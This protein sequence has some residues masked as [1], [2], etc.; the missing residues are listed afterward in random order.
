MMKWK[1]MLKSGARIAGLALLGVTQVVMPNPL[2]GQSDT[3]APPAGV[4]DQGTDESVI[5]DLEVADQQVA[6]SMAAF[7][8]V[9]QRFVKPTAASKAFLDA[10]EAVKRD[11]QNKTLKS[12]LTLAYAGALHDLDQRCEEY[13]LAKKNAED[14]LGSYR[15]AIERRQQESQGKVEQAEKAL[16]QFQLQAEQYRQRF[17]RAAQLDPATMTVAQQRASRLLNQKV[18][19]N[20]LLEKV[21]QNRVQGALSEQERNAVQLT[22]IDSR[23]F[24]YELEGNDVE[25]IR[26]FVHLK[27]EILYAEGNESHRLTNEQLDREHEDIQIGPNVVL[28]DVPGVP[29]SEGL[30]ATVEAE[31]N[32]NARAIERERAALQEIRGQ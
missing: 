31:R 1:R 22:K 5:I 17:D 30:D 32:R 16:A 18:R 7:E 24:E 28:P 6:R 4:A 12:R 27:S 2:R 23:Q 20:T 29:S 19:H 3:I 21:H 8:D 11:P 13:L 25:F 26:E 9:R 14:A 15:A 10:A